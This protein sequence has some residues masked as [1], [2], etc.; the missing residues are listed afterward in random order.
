MFLTSFLATLRAPGA[1]AKPLSSNSVLPCCLNKKKTPKNPKEH[2]II[3]KNPLR[4]RGSNKH[5]S[6]AVV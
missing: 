5:Q 1:E 6:S 2:K 3:K 4:H